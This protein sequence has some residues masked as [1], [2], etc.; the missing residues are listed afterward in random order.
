MQLIF[1]KLILYLEKKFTELIYDCSSNSF[2]VGF[3]EF[4]ICK[5]ISSC[6]KTFSL[7]LSDLN[8]FYCCCCCCCLIVLAKTFSIM[9]NR[10]GDSEYPCLVLDL[11]RKSFNLSPLNMMLT[12][13][14]SYLAYYVEVYTFCIP[15]I[16]SFSS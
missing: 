8:D 2:L 14:L 6:K 5:I 10:S 13:N 11:R 3:L 15:F 7:L 4:S 9:L 1:C 16:E 12:V